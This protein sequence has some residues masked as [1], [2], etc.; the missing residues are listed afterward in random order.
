MQIRILLIT[1]MLI[2]ILIFYFRIQ[3]ITLF[4]AERD[5]DFLFDA[6]PDVDLS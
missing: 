4:D 5:P 1:L 2:G 3:L 6:D